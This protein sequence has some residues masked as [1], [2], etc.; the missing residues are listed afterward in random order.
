MW[1]GHPLSNADPELSRASYQKLFDA[2]DANGVVLAG[3][4]LGNEINWA[5]F[6]PEFPLPGEGK[7]L[8]LADLSNDPEG[9][10]IAKGLLQYLKIL[11]VLKDVRDHSRLNRK[12][13]TISAGM[14]S[15]PDGEKLYNNKREDM[16]S[17]PATMAVLRANGLD[18]LVDGYGIHSYPWADHPGDPVTAFR[19]AVRLETVDLAPCRAAGQAGGKPCWI[20]EWG[21]PNGDYSCPAKDS[22]RA[23]L[24]QE[25]RVDFA[26]AAAEHRLAGITYYSW[27]SDPWSKGPD[28]DSIYRCD[29]L[30][31]AGRLTVAPLE[32]VPAPAVLRPGPA[33]SPSSCG[34]WIQHAE[35]EGKTLYGWVH[36]ETACNYAKGGQTHASMTIATSPDYGLTWKI[37]GPIIVGTD[38]PAD[39]KETGDS[40][41]AAVNGQDGYDYAYCLHNGGSPGTE[42]MA[43]LRARLPP[44]LAPVNGRSSSTVIGPS[45]EWAANQAPS[46]DL[47]SPIGT[48][49]T[50]PSASTGL[51]EGSGFKCPR[52]VCTLRPFSLNL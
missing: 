28:P 34:Q 16:V 37:E 36:N 1:G 20:T 44:T 11:A 50:R 47:V 8:S 12:A 49:H 48:Q 52:T 7:I 21:F 27:N 22:G 32:A 24:I 23:L 6:N 43:L 3:I 46:M 4:E 5:A 19:R 51:K 29:G 25:M 15:A 26:K 14:V 10:Q 31:E 40:C 17:L 45:L 18:S 38:P 39:G 33:G 35:L 2:L 42:A 13:P 9:K 41:P 30:T